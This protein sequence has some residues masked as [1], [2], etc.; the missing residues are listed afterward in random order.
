MASPQRTVSPGAALLRTS[1]MFSIPKPLAPPPGDRS[2]AT[3]HKSQTATASFPTRL[4][5]T[6]TQASR[7]VG[8]WGFKRPLPLKTTL[9]QTH[10][11]VR[12]KQ[13]DSVEH[14]TDFQ[15]ASDHTM[16]LRKFQELGLALTTPS[17]EQNPAKIV[18]VSVFEDDRDFTTAE[19]PQ[20]AESQAARPDGRKAVANTPEAQAAM[21]VNKRWKFRGPWLAGM[22]DGEFESYLAKTVRSRRYEFRQFLREKL[23]S[24]MTDRQRQDIVEK[25][26]DIAPGSIP[27]VLASEVSEEELLNYIRD[28]RSDRPQ[29]YSLVG[30]FLDL[31]PVSNE[32]SLSDMTAFRTGK[33]HHLVQES[34]YAKAGPP[35]THPSAGLSY[36]RTTSYLENHPIY[37]PQASHAPVK[38][39]IVT[40][41]FA[42]PGKVPK[43]GVA[44]FIASPAESN[45]TFNRRSAAYIGRS[46][47]AGIPGLN[48]FDSEAH[49]GSKVYAQVTTAH[50]DAT[51]KIQLKLGEN[52][53]QAEI[54]QKEMVGEGSAFEEAAKESR[55][56]Q[57]PF[58]RP[59]G[60][61]TPKRKVFGDSASYGMRQ[62]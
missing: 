13:V 62:A 9:E 44:G 1:R 16:T 51:G 58:S 4:T 28:I 38:A 40:P 43:L 26:P 55:Q 31:A 29:L 22:T 59:R 15:S 35:I 20:L 27:P 57:M 45:T 14:V 10:P 6:T 48:D 50:V 7:L 3:K 5:V 39:R 42:A 52:D 21:L 30:R 47:N 53:P 11:L 49:G 36:L 60:L 33:A 25:N 12:V 17:H 34:P 2:Q 32:V 24:E 41:R 46:Q 8:D 37:G 19:V 23:A 56:P 54:V 61:P 18:Q